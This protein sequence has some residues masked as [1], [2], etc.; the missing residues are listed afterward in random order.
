MLE[1]LRT[2]FLVATIVAALP[3]PQPDASRAI[4]ADLR[5]TLFGEGV[6][7]TGAY[8]FFVA[9]APDQKTAYLCRA[10]A[11]FGYWTIL[12]TRW[13]GGKWNPPTMAPFSGRWSDADPHF[14]PDGSK[15][16]FISN[17]PLTGD[18]AKAN[19]DL[20]MVERAGAGWGAP[21]PL[22]QICTDATEWSPSVAANGNLYFGATRDG[23]KGR[24]DLWVSRYVDGRYTTPE[25][26]G[27]S[28]NTKFGEVE[29][30]VAPD[31]SYLIFSAGGRADGRGGLDLYISIRR[32]GVWSSARPLGHDINSSGWD[33]N[34]SVSPDGRTFF[35]TSSRARFDPPK[36]AMSYDQLMRK[37]QSPG[38]GLGDIY[39]IPIEALE[40][41]PP[42]AR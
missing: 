33:F 3:T 17:R 27:D 6:F 40:I 29:P 32:D 10:S 4:P 2:M 1:P 34:P 35:F 38:N 14:A 26:L 11:D 8:D 23:G 15:L 19:C 22:T 31:E 9:L 21:R 12:E 41:P 5:P 20:W 28:I 30:W 13:S 39:S 24:D 18:S 37:L 36:T 16:F 25:N 42:G 7:T